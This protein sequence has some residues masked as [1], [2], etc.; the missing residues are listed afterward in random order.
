[1]AENKKAYI[2]RKSCGCVVAAVTA[3]WPKEELAQELG[4]WIRE[5]L[6]VELV[7]DQYVREHFT[8]CHCTAVS[9]PAQLPLL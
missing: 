8:E 1:M 4:E 3:D 7:D 2:G 5:G 9:S 6:T